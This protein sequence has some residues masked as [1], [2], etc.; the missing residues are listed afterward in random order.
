L[1]VDLF[2][3]FGVLFVLDVGFVEL[4]YGE[5]EALVEGVGVE[6]APQQFACVDIS[7]V[8]EG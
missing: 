3:L 4:E 1:F 5:E 6:V 2:A 8:L 7:E